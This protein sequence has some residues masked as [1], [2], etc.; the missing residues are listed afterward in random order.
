MNSSQE[1]VKPCAATSL[2]I[3]IV[4]P[5]YPSAGDNETVI[6]A[7]GIRF[8]RPLANGEVEQIKYAGTAKILAVG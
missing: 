5:G 2:Q 1:T 4:S 6:L 8:G 3:P 7:A